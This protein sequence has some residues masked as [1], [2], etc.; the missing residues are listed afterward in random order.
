VGR[1]CYSDGRQSDLILVTFFEFQAGGFE[2]LL[3]PLRAVLVT[4]LTLTCVGPLGGG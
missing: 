4:F 2:L 1:L 3:G